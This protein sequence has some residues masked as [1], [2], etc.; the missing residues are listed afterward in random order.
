MKKFLSVLLLCLLTLNFVPPA[1]ASASPETEV[2]VLEVNDEINDGMRDYLIR[3]FEQAKEK[4]NVAAIILQMDTPG[5]QVSSAGDI[6][7]AMYDCEIPI[8]T[9]VE[10]QGL[11]AGSYL[12]LASD[13]IAMMPGSTIGDAEVRIGS[14]K[15]D[16][17]YIS[18][19]REEF[20]AMAELNGRDPQI[21][22]AFVDSDIEIPG[23]IDKDKLLVLTANRAY[24]L[25]FCDY[26]VDSQEELL[27]DLGLE[28][29]EVVYGQYSTGERI[30][31]V[32]TSSTIAPIL[33]SGGVICLF[34][35][36]LTP[37]T[38]IFLILGMILLG[39]YFGGSVLA[40]MATWIAVLLFVVG[41]ILCLIELLMPGFGIFGIGGLL[42]IVASI[43]LSTPDIYTAV[44]Y[45]AIMLIALVVLLPILFKFAKKRKFFD[46]LM[47]KNELTTEEGYVSRNPKLNEYVNA[48]GKAL[49]VLR[50]AGTMLTDDGERLDVVTKGDFIEQGERIQVVGIEGTWLIVQKIDERETKEE[51][52]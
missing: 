32:L 24:E 2:L 19:W 4:G 27:A 6:K 28:G 9:L 8:I 17:K 21:A 25:G 20:A 43:F 33:L 22:R 12:A 42:A 45:T 1:Q 16:E 18:A 41:V 10:H 35:E 44:K 29:A 23:I 52:K 7:R 14:E 47:V 36:F 39:L 48:T 26:L 50:P 40:G 15:A 46:K 5:G 13:K 3:H 37:G 30:A 51:N 31:R 38:G 49:S 11:S 34:I